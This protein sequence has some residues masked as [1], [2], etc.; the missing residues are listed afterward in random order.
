MIHRLKED[1]LEE[2]Q[3]D[4]VVSLIVGDSFSIFDSYFWFSICDRNAKNVEVSN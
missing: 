3:K 1:E 4:K 2:V